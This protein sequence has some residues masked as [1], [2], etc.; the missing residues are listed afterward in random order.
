MAISVNCELCGATYRLADS[1]AGKRIKCK[2]CDSPIRVPGGDG[3]TWE[4]AEAPARSRGTS[5]KKKR[6][7]SEGSGGLA[8]VLIGGGILGLVAIIGVG[9]L[10][11]R[12]APAPAPDATVVANESSS[13]AAAATPSGPGSPSPTPATG[14]SAPAVAAAPTPATSTPAPAGPVPTSAPVASPVPAVASNTAAPPANVAWTA[15]ADPPQ[16]TADVPPNLKV[17]IRLSENADKLMFTRGPV[18]RVAVL[19]GGF[20]ATG[21]YVLNLL[22]G[23]QE[24]ENLAKTS[25]SM[26]KALSPDGKTFAI[27]ALEKDQTAK[28]QVM[29]FES[30]QQL[31]LFEA[32]E[33]GLRVNKLAYAGPERLV[34]VVGGNLGGKILSRIR[35]FDVASAK[36]L[37]EVE[38]RFMNPREIAVS[39]GGRFLALNSEYDQVMV[40]DAEQGTIAGTIQVPKSGEDG[41]SISFESLSFTPDGQQVAV[42]L[43]GASETRVVAYDL[44]TGKPAGEHVV[45][46]HIS[47]GTH[48][49]SSYDGPKLQPMPD[50]KGWLLFGRLLLDRETGLVVWHLR[51]AEGNYENSERFPIPGDGLLLVSGQNRA[52]Y[53]TRMQIPRKEID[54]SLKAL[55][56]GAP[57]LL[58]PGQPVNLQITVG[59]LRGGSPEQTKSALEELIGKRLD[60]DDIKVEEASQPMLVKV[61][62]GESAGETLQEFTGDRRSAILGGGTPTGRT[63][64]ATQGVISITFVSRDKKR[65]YWTG[66]AEMNPRRLT[67]RQGEANDQAARDAMFDMLKYSIS[68]QTTPYFIPEDSKLSMLPVL[69]ELGEGPDR[70]RQKMQGRFPVRSRGR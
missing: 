70:S 52:K 1:S 10:L 43:E 13:P 22:T 2:A 42:L 47:L 44:S 67:I 18:P 49:A 33:A 58:K 60:A 5:A 4:E 32:G 57:A 17:D 12:P 23:K 16:E 48:A 36:L 55:A 66:N 15:Q 38:T 31:H 19:P 50:G 3:E 20:E 6:R 56:D 59:N 39:P 28:V 62:Y 25:G 9:V 24:G 53:L 14:P 41:G 34:V 46:G 45:P 40:F 27:N 11:M 63:V 37:H 68:G 61:Q 51:S 64:Q 35:V 65:T 29:S 21:A 69:T 26:D 54:A 7:R 8:P 30:G